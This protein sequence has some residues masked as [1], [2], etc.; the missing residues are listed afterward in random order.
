MKTAWNLDW[1]YNGWKKFLTKGFSYTQEGWNQTLATVI[2]RISVQIHMASDLSG[3]DTVKIHSELL[4]IFESFRYLTKT[5]NGELFISDRYKV[6]IDN[7]L[8]KDRIYV[9][10]ENVPTDAVINDKTISIYKKS[11]KLDKY[12]KLAEKDST[13]NLRVVSQRKLQGKIIVKNF[14]N[15]PEKPTPKKN[16]IKSFFRL[17]IDLFKNKVY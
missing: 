14:S 4:P 15:E 10:L 11:P 7:K 12:K 2:N 17:L 3:A 5:D 8:N 9:Y 6:V 16:N 13:I 1:D